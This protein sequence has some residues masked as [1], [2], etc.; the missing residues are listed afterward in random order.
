M[1]AQTTSMDQIE[2]SQKDE[3]EKKAPSFKENKNL[4]ITFPWHRLDII[5]STIGLNLFAVVVPVLI[6]QLYDRIIPNQATTTLTL[7]AIGVTIVVIFEAILR[8]AR[9]YILGWAGQRFDYNASTGIFSHLMG[10]NLFKLNRMGIGEHIENIESLGTLKEFLAGQ[11]F[12]VLLDLPFL[13]FFLVLISYFGGEMLAISACVILLLFVIASVV[14]GKKLYHSLLER[15]EL[16]DR[17]YSFLIEILNNHYTMKSMGMEEL[18]LRRFERINLQASYIEYKINMLSSEARDV[19]STFSSV[20]FGTIIC[21]AGYDVIHNIISPGA[22]AACLFLSNRLIQPIQ[23]GLSMW[24]RLQHFKIAKER[25]K[26]VFSLPQEKNHGHKKELRGGLKLNNLNFSYD[27]S[28]KELL[29]E[30]NLHIHPGEFVSIIG[31]SG[32]GKTTLSQLIIGSL[33][34]NAGDVLIDD[35]SLTDINMP[36]FRSQIAYLSPKGQIFKGTVMENLTLFSPLQQSDHVMALCRRVGLD[37]WVSQLPL[38]YNTIIGN[39]LDSDIPLGIQQRLCLVRALLLGPK[40][41]ILDEA[42][43]NLDLEG[44]QDFM[45]LLQ[46][47]KGLMTIIFITHRPS[48]ARLS[49]R[50]FELKNKTI[51]ERT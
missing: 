11:G 35:H 28:K 27:G 45:N 4:K 51:V 21:V 5:L 40:I 12:L 44:D 31:D 3:S 32:A 16:G 7:L 30:V 26:N 23:M 47:L 43:T 48:V 2:T 50:V 13:I 19:G 20:L 8:T 6:L 46:E 14:V 10:S 17:K 29:K 42:N 33:E 39:H 9:S 22:M 38:G 1:S 41:L 18:F 34:Q 24:T 15:Q 49:D 36:H 25:Y 37:K